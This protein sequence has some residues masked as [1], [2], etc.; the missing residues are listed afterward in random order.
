MRE[1]ITGEVCRVCGNKVSTEKPTTV[2]SAGEYYHRQCWNKI[3][4][5]DEE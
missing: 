5:S 3:K 4:V 2:Y 1:H